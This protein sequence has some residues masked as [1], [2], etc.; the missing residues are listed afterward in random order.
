MGKTNVL[1]TLLIIC[2]LWCICH[3]QQTAQCRS[4]PGEFKARR[5]DDIAHRQTIQ[6]IHNRIRTL[7]NK[8]SWNVYYKD[9]GSY[10]ASHYQLSNRNNPDAKLDTTIEIVEIGTAFGGAANSLLSHIKSATVSAIDP[11]MAGYDVEDAQSGKYV[12]IANEVNVDIKMLSTVWAE[13]MHHELRGKYSCRYHLYHMTS[14]D[15]V[16]YFAHKDGKP[17]ID[18]IFIDGLHTY[19]GIKKDIEAWVPLVKSGGLVMFNDYSDI[20]ANSVVKAINEYVNATGVTLVQGRR[21]IP[22]GLGNAVFVKP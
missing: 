8:S 17:I 14:D 10:I 18:V 11:F 3:S 15:A 13:A 4:L 2:A 12:E 19:E 1:V 16:Q 20:W 9:V 22:P 6:K 7:R 5:F 21:N